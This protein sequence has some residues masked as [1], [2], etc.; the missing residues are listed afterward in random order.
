M[1]TENQT[2]EEGAVE[3][4]TFKYQIGEEVRIINGEGEVEVG[5]VIEANEKEGV[6]IVRFPCADGATRT[7]RTVG[8]GRWQQYT[9]D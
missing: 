8:G 1:T 3:D 2:F 5:S 4:L 6:I 7:F 9:E